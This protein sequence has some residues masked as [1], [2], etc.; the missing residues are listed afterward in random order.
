VL[1]SILSAVKAGRMDEFIRTLALI[2]TDRSY[3]ADCLFLQAELFQL[4]ANQQMMINLTP[5]QQRVL[6]TN[7]LMIKLTAFGFMMNNTLVA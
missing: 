3:L 5:Q 1:T 6:L 4:K 7:L 2:L